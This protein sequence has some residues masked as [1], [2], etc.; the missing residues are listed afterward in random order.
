MTNGLR[1][2]FDTNVAVSALLFTTSTPGRA[3][4]HVL[5]YGVI[6]T[7]LEVVTELNEVLSRD[8]FDKYVMRDEREA[9][10]TAL[11]R[12]SDEEQPATT[13]GH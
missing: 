3:F 9:F 13:V 6:L 12:E 11:V 1:C 5:E 4:A 8:K 2:V 7:S 10:V